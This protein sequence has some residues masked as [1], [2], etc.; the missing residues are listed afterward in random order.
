MDSILHDET[1]VPDKGARLLYSVARDKRY[2]CMYEVPNHPL[3]DRQRIPNGRI[4]VTMIDSK[5][6]GMQAALR[7]EQDSHMLKCT[8]EALIA[9]G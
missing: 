7:L 4:M 5:L 8:D 1:N 9:Q 6:E 3:V 2:P